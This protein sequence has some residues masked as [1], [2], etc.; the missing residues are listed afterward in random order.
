M[1]CLAKDPCQRPGS[2]EQLA[3]ELRHCG[4]EAWGQEEARDWWGQYLPG[5]AVS[6]STESTAPRREAGAAPSHS[7]PAWTA[8]PL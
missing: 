4:T 6:S 5:E 8:P 2:A 3:D 1:A 7:A